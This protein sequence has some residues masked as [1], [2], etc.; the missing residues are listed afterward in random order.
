MSQLGFQYRVIRSPRR[1]T[2]AIKISEEGIVVRVPVGVSDAWIEHWLQSRA[3]WVRKHD[4]ELRQNLQQFC[5]KVEQGE[6]I[7]LLGKPLQLRWFSGPRTAVTQGPDTL[8]ICLS[9]RSSKPEEERV[10]TCLKTWYKEQ[11]E[12]YLPERLKYWERVTGLFCNDLKIKD[13]KRRWGS[14]SSR[15][16]VSLNWRLM[17]VDAALVDH[18]IIHELAHLQHLDHSPRFWKLVEKHCPD[19][20]CKKEALQKR[21]GWVL[22]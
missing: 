17:C 1:R 5:L 13:F 9:Q 14:C 22:W 10:R 11:A 6:A 2:A 15:G 19:W 21:I 16:E 7:S 12:D 18:V 20:R 3:A 4:A 8:Q